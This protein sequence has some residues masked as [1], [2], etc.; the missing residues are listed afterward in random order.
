MFSK[1]FMSYLLSI[2]SENAPKKEEKTK[3][4]KFSMSKCIKPIAVE[5][6]VK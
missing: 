3:E 2:D 6:R 4:I 1:E 5:I